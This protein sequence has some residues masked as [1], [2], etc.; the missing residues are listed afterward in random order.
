MDFELDGASFDEIR[1]SMD[2]GI[3]YER[4]QQERRHDKVKRILIDIFFHLDARA[5]ADFFDREKRADQRQLLV[6]RN[7]GFLTEAKRAAQEVTEKDAHLAGLG[8]IGGGERADGIEAVE[9]EMRIHL[10][11]ER[12]QFRVA[13]QNSCFHFAFF[14]FLR[15]LDRQQDIEKCDRKQIEQDSSAEEKR[16]ILRKAGLETVEGREGGQF[17]R[18]RFRRQNPDSADYDCPKQMREGDL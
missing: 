8:G 14:R 6:E 17:M 15:L 18:Q 4:L 5:E 2:D 9:K 12:P 10:G 1:D 13:S 7:R 11:F 16:E 3:F